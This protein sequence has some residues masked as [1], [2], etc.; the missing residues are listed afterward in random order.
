M[1]NFS[2][3]MMAEDFWRKLEKLT[4]GFCEELKIMQPYH[5]FFSLASNF[6]GLNYILQIW[7]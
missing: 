3:S 1:T 4:H 6:M 5:S 2:K 7:T